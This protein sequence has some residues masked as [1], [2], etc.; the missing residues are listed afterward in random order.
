MG[1]IEELIEKYKNIE[2]TNEYDP[3]ESAF[4]RGECA[5]ESRV[6]FEIVEDLKQ[7]KSSLPTQQPITKNQALARLAEDLPINMFELSNKLDYI[8]AGIIKTDKLVVDQFIADWYKRHESDL[9]FGIWDYIHDYEGHDKDS[10][11]FKW[12]EYG[13]NRPIETLIRMKVGYTVVKEPLYYVKVGDKYFQSWLNL[14]SI[15]PV[16]ISN[17]SDAWVF[18]KKN[19]ADDVAKI[20]GGIAVLVEEVGE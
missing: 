14:T 13:E 7:L 17:K 11:F 6:A 9:E 2:K 16:C 1:K 3:M 12:F 10:E 4:E 15:T 5:G 20:I 19:Q 8:N 18:S